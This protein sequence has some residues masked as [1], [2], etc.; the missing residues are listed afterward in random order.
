MRGMDDH[1]RSDRTARILTSRLDELARAL[2]QAA[3]P[4]EVAV[5]LLESASVA[6][7]HAITL[8]LLTSSRASA[9]WHEAAERHPKVEP[10]VELA[11]FAA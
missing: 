4:R 8:D 2:E 7:M 10:L 3:V 11:R 6:T 5:T 1:A 9:L